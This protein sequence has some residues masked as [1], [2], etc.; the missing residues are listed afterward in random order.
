VVHKAL[1]RLRGCVR[2][3]QPGDEGFYPPSLARVPGA[4]DSLQALLPLEATKHGVLIA[5]DVCGHG[6]IYAC[7]LEKVASVV[8]TQLQMATMKEGAG[9]DDEEEEEE[10][11][12]ESG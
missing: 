1:E 3:V 4:L 2:V 8:S 11:D 9:D 6:P 7:V 12:E 5:P 10:G